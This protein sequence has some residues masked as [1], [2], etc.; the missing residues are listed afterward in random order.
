MVFNFLV[1]IDLGIV[2]LFSQSAVKN[3][4]RTPQTNLLSQINRVSEKIL[5]YLCGCCERAV[6]SIIS[7]FRQLHRSG[8]NL[9]FE[10]LFESI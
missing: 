2:D 6:N 4:I 3:F 9:E 5:L 1:N 10:T 8:F 7:A